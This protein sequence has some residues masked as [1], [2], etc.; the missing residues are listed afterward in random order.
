MADKETALEALKTALQGITIANGYALDV[1]KVTRQF[2][3][4]DQVAA[5]SFPVLII[6]DDGAEEI[7]FKTSG[8]ADMQIQ[9]NIIGYV[10]NKN[11]VSTK[12]NQLDAALAKVLHG[13]QTLAGAVGSVSI[14]PVEERSGSKFKPY[15]F[16]KRPVKL[17]YE[18]QLSNGI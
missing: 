6:E 14:E 11:A 10:K 13:E 9:V 15:G 7:D 17:F 18:V 8:F 4:I 16:F 1:K 12:L 3:H 2:Q 5:T